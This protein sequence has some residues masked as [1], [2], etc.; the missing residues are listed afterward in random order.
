MIATPGAETANLVLRPLRTA[1][2]TQEYADG[3]NDPEVNR[4]LEV[5]RARQTLDSARAFV[6]AHENAPDAVLLGA[7][8]KPGG[9]LIG[10]IRL[11]EI[12]DGSA[13]L[14]ICLFAKDCWG[15]GLGSEALGAAC[16]LAF[17]AAGVERLRAGSYEANAASLAL[18]QKAGF[19]ITGR[20]EGRLELDGAPAPTVVMELARRDR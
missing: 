1:D 3:L 7:F 20:E 9:R 19:N 5:R 15:R 8:L 18:F 12:K 2:A 16:R 11:H 17:D 10:T 13:W 14:G 6:A 4:F